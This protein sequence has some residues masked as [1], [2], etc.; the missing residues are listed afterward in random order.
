MKRP[1]IFFILLGLA[2]LAGL[3]ACVAPSPSTPDAAQPNLPN[4]ASVFCQEQ[5]YT[6]EIRDSA[7]GQY[8]VCIFPDGTECD[9][10]AYYRG[11]CSPTSADIAPTSVNQARDSALAYV[12]QAYGDVVPAGELAWVS[13]NTTPTD[14]LGVGSYRFTAGTCAVDVTYPIV[15]PDATVF[16]VTV[17][18]SGTNFH[19]EGDVDAQ[20]AVILP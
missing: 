14:L 1:D 17:A 13:A 4:P 7:T 2:W 10:W 19:W 9:E 15:A 20:G 6:L 18:D 16:H 8:G 12:R 3:G 5:G 11:Q